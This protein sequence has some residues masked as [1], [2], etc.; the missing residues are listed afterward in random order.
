M[1]RGR[2]RRIAAALLA[3]VLS[4]EAT[5]ATD[6]A[7]T[8]AASV[9]SVTSATAE[10]GSSGGAAAAALDPDEAYRFSQAAVG[11]VLGDY[12][13]LDRGGRQVRLASYRGKPLLVNFVYTG[14][15]S[16]CPVTTQR[17][18]DLIGAAS[19]TLGPGQFNV[20]S[21]GINPPADSPES[22]R[23]FARRF[24]LERPNW[25]FLTPYEQQVGALAAE[26]GFRFV[27]TSW[28]FD[29]V[30]QVTIVDAQGRVDRQIYGADFELRR[31]VDPLQALI[32]GA[33]MP[34]ASVADVFD[35]VRILCTIYD[36]SAG[37]Y[38]FDYS[39]IAQLIGI[40]LASLTLLAFLFVELR[41]RRR[42]SR[43]VS[44]AQRAEPADS[45]AA[46][47]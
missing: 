29:H 25:E 13:F 14:C 22:M 18:A 38:R 17:I 16:A 1:P 12:A 9:P 40:T 37:A 7:A 45:A 30:A 42:A 6:T 31:L 43:A 34:V 4:W 39:I 44:P 24:G 8:R 11:R 26:F 46:S 33:P 23:D 3:V 27:P 2:Q 21:I 41:R 47:A 20:V 32:T 19:R 10:S 5:A 35:R 15:I 28:G 36:P